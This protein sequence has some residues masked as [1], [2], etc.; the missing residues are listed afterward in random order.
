M[1]GVESWTELRDAA[2]RLDQQKA[3]T[4]V[5]GLAEQIESGAVIGPDVQKRLLGELRRVRWFGLLE[6]AAEALVEAG[7]ATPLAR[8]QYGQALIELGRLDQALA[9]VEAL[10]ADP[11]CPP[12]EWAE[13]RGLVGRI[14]KQFYVD[15]SATLGPARRPTLE[16]SVQAYISVYDKAPAVHT[17]HGINAVAMTLRGRRDGFALSAKDDPLSL[18]EKILSACS[19]GPDPQPHW[20]A[21]T[22]A[23]ACVALGKWSEAL[24]WIETYVKHPEVDAFSCASTL[25]QLRQVWQLTEDGPGGSLL[26]ILQPAVL[27]APNQS[28]KSA[29]EKIGAPLV[30]EAGDLDS[31]CAHAA[32]RGETL[33]KVFGREGPRSRGWY[34]LGLQ[35]ARGVARIEKLDGTGF[36]TGFLIHAA[37]LFEPSDAP[38]ELLL[39]TNSHVISAREAAALRPLDARVRFDAV[40]NRRTYGVRELIFES[41]PTELDVAIV[42]LDGAVAG[43]EPAVLAAPEEPSFDAANPRQFYVIGYPLGGELSLSLTD[44]LQVGWSAPKLHYRTPTRP[45]NSGSPVF[46]E[47]WRLVAVH[48]AGS[49]VMQRLDGHIGAYEA[50]EGIWIHAVIAEI[51]KHGLSKAGSTRFRSAKSLGTESRPPVVQPE[52]RTSVFISYAHA[53]TRSLKELKKVMQPLFGAT[54]IDLWDDERIVPGSNWRSEIDR[55]LECASIAILLV[56]VDFLASKFILE[57]EFPR[58]LEANQKRGLTILPIAIG[59]SGWDL[60]PA[61]ARLQF[62]NDPKKPLRALKPVER[63]AALVAIVKHLGEVIDGAR[64]SNPLRAID[65]A[66]FQATG[67]GGTVKAEAGLGVLGALASQDQGDIVLVNKGVRRTIIRLD[68]LSKLDVESRKLIAVYDDA[69]RRA[70]EGWAAEYGK[71]PVGEAE[72]TESASRREAFRAD[73]CAHFNLLLDFF[74]ARNWD[75]DDHYH[76]VRHICADRGAPHVATSSSAGSLVPRSPPIL[77]DLKSV[78]KLAQALQ[79]QGATEA[80]LE[81]TLAAGDAELRERVADELPLAIACLEAAERTAGVLIAPENRLAALLQS[82]LVECGTDGLRERAGIGAGGESDLEARFDEHDF[83]GWALKFVP[84]W[85]KGRFEKKPF[86]PASETVTSIPDDARIAI[87]GDWGTGLYG[88]PVC[89]DSIA[90]SQPALNAIVHLGDVYYAGTS[91]EVASRFLDAWPKVSGATNWALNSNHEMYSGGEGYFGKTLQDPRFS[92][93]S[94]CFSFQNSYFLFLG[95]DTAYQEHDISASQ[96][97]WITR[98]IQN[99][100]TRRVVLLS[101]HQP[102]SQFESGGEKLQAKL[103]AL[104][105][106]KQ[107]YAWYWG[108]EHRCALFDQ[109]PTWGFLGRCIG[110]SGYPAFRDKFHETQTFK[111]PDG[112]RWVRVARTSAPPA[113]VLDGTNRYV[114][115]HADE[116]APN[117]YLTLKLEGASLRETVRA[118]DGTVLPLPVT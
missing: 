35:R 55:A 13:A 75:L 9:V 18:A 72:G 107:I 62:V 96:V 61:L 71:R 106:G 44:S 10:A 47:S 23:E 95:L 93:K 11:T 38:D 2:D 74:A 116:Y 12:G 43:V 26:T 82:Y 4:I 6:Q 45:G 24:D 98:R 42:R 21:A 31:A 102:F 94:S 89:S 97:A 80:A 113:Y 64:L 88:A 33:E 15:R 65:A 30:L 104:L 70:F 118:P 100:G 29:A 5:E 103:S 91:N 41:G 73:L 1:W 60:V 78:K 25:R 111:N 49:N 105:T 52:F 109:H 34:E 112:S 28:T 32:G 110:H 53:D 63:Q 37:S 51:A 48:H 17:W 67:L 79:K 114:E 46:D 68:D 56:S 8:R 85:L 115:G 108:H 87:L 22:A 69:I 77:A 16:A 90:R 39:V 86:L 50:N 57:T 3:A 36:G 40:D 58:L 20:D 92:N 101:H 84:E 83:A 27:R 14:Y 7:V 99:A 66:A 81:S 76:A 117:G 19:S 59:P 54:P